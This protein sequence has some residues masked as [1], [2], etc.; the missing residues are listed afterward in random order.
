MP[1]S[2]KRGRQLRA[3]ERLERQLAS[4]C[5]PAGFKAHITLSADDRARISGELRTLETALYGRPVEP[6][7]VDSGPRPWSTLVNADPAAEM[8]ERLAHG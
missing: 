8:A 2:R 6:E 5:K 7:P 1:N 4:N 3:A